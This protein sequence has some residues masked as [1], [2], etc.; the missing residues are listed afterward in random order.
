MFRIPFTKNCFIQSLVEFAF[1]KSL[2]SVVNQELNIF[3]TYK[4]I[5]IDIRYSN[6]DNVVLYI[7]HLYMSVELK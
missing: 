6:I 2:K 7:L 3:I 5:D 1:P 4:K